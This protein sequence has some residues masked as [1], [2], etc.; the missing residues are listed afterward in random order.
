M[1]TI[2]LFLKLILPLGL[3]AVFFQGC[4]TQ[5]AATRGEDL[6]Y[7]EEQQPVAQDD[8]T[9]YG[10]GNDNWQSHP[11][12][13][14]AYYY[15][16]WNSY[17][18]WDYG[19]V[20]P[21]YWD[22]WYWGPAFYIGY[23]YYPHHW[24][25][26]TGYAGYRYGYSSRQFMTRNSGYLRSGNSRLTGA[27]RS[28][29]TGTGA[30]Y[31]GRV[32]VSRG[33]VNLSRTAGSTVTTR[34]SRSSSTSVSASRQRGS[35]YNPS[36]QQPLHRGQSTASTNRRSYRISSSHP[37]AYRSQG[38]SSGQSRPASRRSSASAA[39]SNGGGGHQS[40]GS[41]RSQR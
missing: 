4:Y 15:P 22:P 2:K 25:Y 7:Q 30:A 12:L 35:W 33:N 18:S 10:E 27:A 14:F 3:I 34:T 17:W 20:Y 24:G 32:D 11:Y 9:Y 21:S 29:Y 39:R 13:G 41:G 8:S 26:W 1:K 40:S 31:N 16:G 6:S 5:V 23:S 36:V 28:G 37:R 38:A 19:C